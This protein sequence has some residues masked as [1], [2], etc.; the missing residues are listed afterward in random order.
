MV[1]QVALA[2]RVPGA[3]ALRLMFSPTPRRRRQWLGALAL[4][5]PARGK[6]YRP[7][8]TEPLEDRRLL[9]TDFGDA[10]DTLPD[11]PGQGTVDVPAYPTLLADDGARHEIVEGGPYLGTAPDA[12]DDG[13]PDATATGDDTSGDDDEDGVTGLDVAMVPGTNHDSPPLEDL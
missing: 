7:L 9:A 12:E 2:S 3:R 4:N 13:Q 10:P 6:S 11:P 5:R 1:P 8:A